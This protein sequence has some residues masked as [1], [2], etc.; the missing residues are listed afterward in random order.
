MPDINL[1]GPPVS[2]SSQ[3]PNR[4]DKTESSQPLSKSM[5]SLK[6]IGRDLSKPSKGATLKDLSIPLPRNLLG[7]TPNMNDDKMNDNPHQSLRLLT[8]IIP[9]CGMFI[10]LF[11]FSNNLHFFNLIILK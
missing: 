6:E 2:P 9:S 4:S 1:D 11:N 3:S 8:D 10:S 5:P 7:K